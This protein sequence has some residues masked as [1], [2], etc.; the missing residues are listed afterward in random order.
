[1]VNGLDVMNK[2]NR[3]TFVTSNRQE[4]IDITISTFYLWEED[5]KE[6]SSSASESVGSDSLGDVFV[7]FCCSSTL[8]F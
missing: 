5:H 2:G 1:M 8:I 6:N 7:T 4:V 3:P